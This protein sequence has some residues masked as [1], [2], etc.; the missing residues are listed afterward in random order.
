[1][2]PTS[3]P[4]LALAAAGIA[5]A[6]PALAEDR[7]FPTTVFEGTDESASVTSDGVTATVTVVP[8]VDPGGLYVPVLTV[9]VDGIKVAEATGA[10][11]DFDMR[12][13]EA[14]IAE[15]DPGNDYPEVYFSSFSGGAHCCTTVMVA[16]QVGNAWVVTP[17]GDFDGDGD[18]LEDLDGDGLAEIVTVDNRF[19][20]R[21]DSYAASAA[22][23]SIFTVRGGD[24]I[25]I[26]AEQR[27]LPGHREWLEELAAAAP[28]DRWSSPGYLA[29]WL[30]TRVRLGEG[31]EAWEELNANWDS[32]ADEGEE[33]CLT[34]GEP[35]DCAGDQIEVL[36]F[37]QRLRLFLSQNGYEF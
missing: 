4:G 21:F 11:T 16:S 22:P 19:L 28:E 15:I 10:E 2:P 37:P 35:E 20:Y 1:L 27:F 24:V 13:A 30:A 25:D 6:A 3:L 23:L 12:A 34:G 7:R 36:K 33:T 26:S 18:Y 17:V 14:M 5:L 32:A 9:S 8:P 31:P 29:G